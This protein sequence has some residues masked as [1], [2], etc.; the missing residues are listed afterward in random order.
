MKEA[1]AKRF[2][3]TSRWCIPLS[4]DGTQEKELEATLLHLPVY[5]NVNSNCGFFSEEIKKTNH[6]I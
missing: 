6:T 2:I 5:Q 1:G 4:N 3:T